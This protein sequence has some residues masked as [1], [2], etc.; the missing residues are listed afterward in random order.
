MRHHVLSKRGC[1]VRSLLS[2]AR[3][4]EL[5]APFRRFSGLHSSANRVGIIFCGHGRCET[6]ESSTPDMSK[7]DDSHHDSFFKKALSDPRHAGTF[8]RE[9]LP[10]DVAGLLDHEEPT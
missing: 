5:F 1:D 8:L 3:K 9:H 7:Q 2:N 10:P 4:S 6:F